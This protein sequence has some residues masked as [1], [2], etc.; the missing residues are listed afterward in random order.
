MEQDPD[1][2][3]RDDDKTSACGASSQDFNF[4]HDDEI[5][6]E[7]LP[8]TTEPAEDDTSTLE[9]PSAFM[10]LSHNSPESSSPGKTKA[11]AMKI[12]KECPRRRRIEDAC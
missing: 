1:Q 8:G 9:P 12:L 10:N 3:R 11:T 4:L 7:T 5:G 2:V 6:T